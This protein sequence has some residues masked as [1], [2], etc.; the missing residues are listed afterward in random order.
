[1]DL[2]VWLAVWMALG[3]AHSLGLPVEFA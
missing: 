2:M 1:V 3:W